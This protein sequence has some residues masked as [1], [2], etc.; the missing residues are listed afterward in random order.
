MTAAALDLYAG[1]RVLLTGHSG[2]KGGWLATWLT[3]LGADVVG[4]SLPP[5]TDPNLFTAASI[6]DRVQ[7]IEGDVRDLDHLARVWRDARPD[8]V[9]HLAAQAIV[10]ESYRAPLDT[11]Q[12][13]VIGT[14]NVLEIAR[15][16]GRAVAIVLVTSDKCYENKE[17]IYGY[18]ENDRL[19]GRDIYSASKAAAE[20]VADSYRRS[21]FP[22]ET[23]EHHGVAVAT[24]RAGNVIGGGDWSPDRI[25]PDSIRALSRG[26]PVVVRNPAATRP[27][28]HVLEPLSGY[29]Q[30]G[31]RLLGEGASRAAACDAWNFGPDPAETRSVQDVV[32]HLIARFG[33]GS[34]HQDGASGPHESGL[35]R[36]ATD[37]ARLRLGWEPR[38]D[39]T[40][41]IDAT[42]DWY[43]AFYAGDPMAAWCERQIDEHSTLGQRGPAGREHD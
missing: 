34:W 21:F 10:R 33:R 30:L 32:E 11:I 24:A 13:N 40:R 42:V 31:A 8:V 26:E 17:W 29:L 6:A 3:R 18:R 7:S 38:W 22:P 37:K 9:F 16:E 23:V 36:L 15:R 4:Y 5:S 25:V 14:A 43:K 1:K 19:G 41:T 28:Q 39:F 35:L 20:I 12:T 27:W 2:F